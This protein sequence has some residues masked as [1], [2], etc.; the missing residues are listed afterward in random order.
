MK[1]V[2]FAGGVGTRLWPLSRRHSPKQ[3]EKVIG[4]KSTLELAVERLLPDFNWEDIYISTNKNYVS[5]VKN[6]VPNIYDANI[7]GEPELRDVG[8]A[9]GLITAILTTKHPHEPLVILWSD[10]IVKEDVF[11]RNILKL[12]AK[13]ISSDGNKIIFISQKPRFASQNLGWIKF[14]N[15]KMKKDNITLYEF[16]GFYYHPDLNLAQKFYKDGHYGWNVG[17]FVTTPLFLWNLFKKYQPDLYRMLEEIKKAVGTPKFNTLLKRIY[18]KL[19]KISFDNAILEK[20]TE[21]EA[22]VISENLGW[23]DVGAWEALKEALQSSPEQNITHGKVLIQDCRDTLLYN[24]TKQM[25]V[26]IDLNGFMVINTNDVILVC[27]KN[28]VPK[29]KK[30]VQNLANSRDQHLA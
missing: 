30:L 14:G 26:A 25:L 11:F 13:I 3:F 5:Q 18:P 28:S 1:A 29:I 24:Y 19:P 20:I 12:C 27:H 10:H 4:D 22:L 17:Y 8:P 7:I 9:V 6:L 2:I 21:N 16:K 15:V 23:S